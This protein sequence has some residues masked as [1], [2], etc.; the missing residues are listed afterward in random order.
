MPLWLFIHSYLAQ[1]RGIIVMFYFIYVFF[2][3]LELE[4]VKRKYEELKQGK[5]LCLFV[6]F[7]C[8]RLWVSLLRALRTWAL[9]V[10]EIFLVTSTA[11]TLYVAKSKTI[12][13]SLQT[14]VIINC[15]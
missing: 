12:K 2:F 7:L 9:I 6:Y 3:R 11:S 15:G 14:F 8:L 10:A 1:A 13:E 5:N 4:Q